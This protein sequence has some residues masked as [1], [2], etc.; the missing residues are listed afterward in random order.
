[1][2][3]ADSL[4]PRS[5][6]W[7]VCGRQ[8]LRTLKFAIQELLKLSSSIVVHCSQRQNSTGSSRLMAT[9]GAAAARRAAPGGKRRPQAHSH[10]PEASVAAAATPSACSK[11]RRLEARQEPSIAFISTA[12]N[13]LPP[14]HSDPAATHEPEAICAVRSLPRPVLEVSIGRQ[15]GAA[16]CR[17]MGARTAGSHMGQAPND[18]V[19]FIG[20]DLASQMY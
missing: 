19:T 2:G 13:L 6:A 16:A 17:D 12:H 3:Q 5:A 11:V 1:M 14:P 4:N 8:L 7:C 18:P 20:M 15:R 9:T 10:S